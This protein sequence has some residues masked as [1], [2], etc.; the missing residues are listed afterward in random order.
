LQY[1]FNKA[2]LQ[3]VSKGKKTGIEEVFSHTFSNNF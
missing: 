1:I 2:N 3:S